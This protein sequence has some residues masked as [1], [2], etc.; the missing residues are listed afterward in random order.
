[1][2]RRDTASFTLPNSATPA[3]FLRRAQ[4]EGHSGWPFSAMQARYKRMDQLLSLIGYVFAAAALQPRMAASRSTQ[5][6]SRIG[7]PNGVTAPYA[8]KG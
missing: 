2:T 6:D 3:R 5:P 8:D 7:D 4:R 1:M